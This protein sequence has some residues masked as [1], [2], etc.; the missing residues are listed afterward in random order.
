MHDSNFNA[1]SWSFSVS[2]RAA[3]AQSAA[4]GGD[5]VLKSTFCFWPIS[6]DFD[7]SNSIPTKYNI[8]NTKPELSETGHLFGRDRGGLKSPGRLT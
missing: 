4:M 1:F 2:L 3:R 5:R 7:R 6:T 8:I